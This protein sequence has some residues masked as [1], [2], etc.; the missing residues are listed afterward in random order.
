MWIQIALGAVLVLVLFDLRPFPP[1]FSAF[2]CLDK[3]LTLGGCISQAP[4]PADFHWIQ[5]LGNT[6][7]RLVGSRKGATEVFF[8][9]LLLS[10]CS[11]SKDDCV[12]LRFQ[13]LPAP[14]L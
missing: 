12:C 3:G 1:L 4:L 7:E 5:S 14:G 9:C 6:G 8:S 13:F 11:D 2:L 10:S